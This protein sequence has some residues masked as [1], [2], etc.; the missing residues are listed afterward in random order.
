MIV[1]ISALAVFLIGAWLWADSMRAREAALDAGR[2]ACDAEGLQFLDWTVAMK[3]MGISRASDGRLRMRRIYEFEF[4]ETGNDRFTGSITM[5]G[6]HLIA[7]HLAAG[8]RTD[9]GVAHL[10]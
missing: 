3:R 5:L 4:S 10:H 6:T 2:R 8:N 7:L 1:E 9:T